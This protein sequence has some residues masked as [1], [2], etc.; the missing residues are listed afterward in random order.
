MKP[1]NSTTA[2]P[3]V[4]AKRPKGARAG[5][6]TPQ[7][8]ESARS[9]G[10]RLRGDDAQY[11]DNGHCH[12]PH[13]HGDHRS[14]TPALRWMADMLSL[15]G[16]CGRPACRRARQ[17]KCEPRDCL[18]RYAPLAPELARDGVKVLLDALPYRIDYDDLREDAPDEVTALEQW[19]ARVAQSAAPRDRG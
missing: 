13:R 19:R 12:E 1:Q 2:E 15:W 11:R 18:A 17:C 4:P 3:L 6:H 7:S 14:H 9:M 16:L 8:I 5:T 10:L